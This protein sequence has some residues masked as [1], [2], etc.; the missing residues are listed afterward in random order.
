MSLGYYNMDGMSNGD[1]SV[2]AP[3]AHH[4]H[5]IATLNILESLEDEF[6]EAPLAHAP[7]SGHDDEFKP[8]CMEPW[9][10]HY[11]TS[12]APETLPYVSSLL[13]PESMDDEEEEKP[14][15]LNTGIPASVSQPP[16]SPEG[17]SRIGE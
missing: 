10:D 3:V 1:N 11:L 7:F 9:T 15:V 16:V 13:E 4:E 6:P 2:P 8:C 5:Y 12:F 17:P 14:P